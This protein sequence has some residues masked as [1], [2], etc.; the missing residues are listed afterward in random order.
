VYL[1]NSAAQS[2]SA[3]QNFTLVAPGTSVSNSHTYTVSSSATGRY[4]L[5][6]FTSL[7]PAGGQ[8]QGQISQITMRGS[9]ANGAG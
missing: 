5:I 7:P 6:W 4:V 3:L 1:G 2:K 9:A 8:F